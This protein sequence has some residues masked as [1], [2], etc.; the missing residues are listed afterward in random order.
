MIL[1]TIIYTNAP[2]KGISEPTTQHIS[3]IY[4]DILIIVIEVTNRAGTSKILLSKYQ[5]IFNLKTGYSVTIERPRC[6]T[7]N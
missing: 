2:I 7:K 1:L 3:L 5:G 6:L 4:L